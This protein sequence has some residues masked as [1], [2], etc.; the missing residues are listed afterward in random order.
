M[1]YA[2]GEPLFCSKDV[3]EALGYSNAK[4]AVKQYVEPEDVMKRDTPSIALAIKEKR[5]HRDDVS[6]CEC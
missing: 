5:A 4:D 2:E 1:Q 6:S 3:C